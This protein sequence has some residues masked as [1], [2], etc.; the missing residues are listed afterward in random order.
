MYLASPS[1][2]SSVN[3][4]LRRS[5]TACGSVIFNAFTYLSSSFLNDFVLS[6]FGS[7]V[8]S[9]L[10]D[11]KLFMAAFLSSFIVTRFFPSI[12]LYI[13][14]IGLFR[15]TSI[16]EPVMPLYMSVSHSLNL[17]NIFCMDAV[18]AFPFAKNP[19][20][21]LANFSDTSLFHDVS[22]AHLRTEVLS[23]SDR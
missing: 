18:G 5:M 4:F 22:F 2:I 10:L 7:K 11:P 12:E 13:S 14:L 21:P 6:S 23:W 1:D 9:S 8:F 19:S 3:S 16:S 15:R 17:S 20:Y